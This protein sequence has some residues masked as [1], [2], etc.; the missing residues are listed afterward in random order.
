LA[1]EMKARMLATSD[2]EALKAA[3]RAEARARRL[4]ISAEEAAEAARALARHDLGCLGKPGVLGAYHPVR[5]EIDCLPLVHHLRGSGWSV[6]LPVIVEGAPLDF[7]LWDAGIPLAAGPFGI[8]QPSGTPAVTPNV[9]LVPFLA[10][11]AQGHRLGYGG[12]FYDRTLA[13][14]RQ[15]G[16]L[17]A[18]G[19]A[20]DSQE[21]PE[22][23]AGPHDQRLDW[24]LTPSR[25]IAMAK[26]A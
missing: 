19:L 18:I 21:V 15:N 7:H 25:R 10:F 13:A 20:Y 26:G 2:V 23:P 6:A 8:P 5:S 9:L 1:D 3:M 14:L 16:T 24:V 12:G 11:D 17:I 22:V 4:A